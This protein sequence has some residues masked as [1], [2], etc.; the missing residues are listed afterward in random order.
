[1]AIAIYPTFLRKVRGLP[2]RFSPFRFCLAAKVVSLPG[3]LFRL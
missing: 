2:W 3:E 1:M